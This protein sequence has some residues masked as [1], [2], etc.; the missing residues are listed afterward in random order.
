ME[1]ASERYHVRPRVVG[2]RRRR[3]RHLGTHRRRCH[4]ERAKQ[5]LEN[6]ESS[7]VVQPP[8]CAEDH[9]VL[10]HDGLQPPFGRVGESAATAAAHRPEQIADISFPDVTTDPTTIRP[11]RK[12]DLHFLHP[13]AAHAQIGTVDRPTA[14]HQ[15][16]AEP[17]VP[18]AAMGYRVASFL[19]PS[20]P[21]CRAGSQEG[22]RRSRRPPLRS[23]R[24]GS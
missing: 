14:P 24:L 5:G 12:D 19:L 13:I 11:V 2:R 23:G 17:D 7:A 20:S 22:L 1:Y 6:L 18:A 21:P 10:H 15:V 16:G 8:A 4:V 9:H 3:D